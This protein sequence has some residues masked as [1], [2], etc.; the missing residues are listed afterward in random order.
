MYLDFHWVYTTVHGD[1]RWPMEVTSNTYFRGVLWL[2]APAV[3]S[4]I[5][6]NTSGQ[7]TNQGHFKQS[8]LEHSTISLWSVATCT[9]LRL[10]GKIDYM[11][12][13]T[14]K[15]VNACHCQKVSRRVA[16]FFLSDYKIYETGF[17][18][19]LKLRALQIR[20]QM[21]GFKVSIPAPLRQWKHTRKHSALLG[22]NNGQCFV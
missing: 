11:T 6:Q 20:R 5:R 22:D 21:D 12:W 14:R 1:E 15:T 19:L 16:R 7:L 13:L 17:K 4:V 8:M 18:K 9:M 3:F 2:H 10:Y